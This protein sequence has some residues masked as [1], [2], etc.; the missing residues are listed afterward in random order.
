VSSAKFKKEGFKYDPN[1]GRGGIS[2]T[3]TSVEPKRPQ[4]IIDSTGAKGADKY[5]DID[6]KGKEVVLKGK[7]KGGLPDWK[8][9]E[10]VTPADVTNSGSVRK[11]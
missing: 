7:T 9:K 1:D 8:I 11:K 3:S 10:D 4:A 2:A 6:T 5:V